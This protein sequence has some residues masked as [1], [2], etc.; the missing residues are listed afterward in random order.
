M[1]TQATVLDRSQGEAI[2][3][4]LKW[5]YAVKAYDRSKKVSASDMEV[6]EESILLAPSSFGIQPYK[7]F[8]ITDPEIRERLKAAAYGQSAIT[9]ASHLIV[10]AYKKTLG[11][12]DIDQFIER[13]VEVRGQT[14]ESLSA[15]EESVRSA[16]TRAVDGGYIETW[17]SRQAYIALGL[18]IQTAALLNIDVTPMEG[19]DP[20]GVNGILGLKDHSAVAIAAIGYRDAENDWLAPLPKVRKPKSDLIE[21]I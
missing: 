4:K 9:D 16:V 7:A 8:V 13:I 19:F 11:E 18:L 10:F 12:D 15:L 17:N 2:L 21:R 3:D 5:R 6:L 1:G 14:R 20:Q